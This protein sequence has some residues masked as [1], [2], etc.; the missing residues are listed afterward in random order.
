MRWEICLLFII[1]LSFASGTDVFIAIFPGAVII[2]AVMLALLRMAADAFSLPS[3]S[4]YV[5]TELGELVSGVILALIVYAFI[6]GSDQLTTILTGK[7]ATDLAMAHF[8]D[9]I[10]KYLDVYRGIIRIGTQL[11]A[12]VSFNT[13]QVLPAMF[14]SWGW[15]LG[16]YAGLAPFLTSLSMAVQ[17]VS[18]NILLYQSVLLL[19]S[20]SRSVIGPIVLPIALALRL[21]PF[22]RQAGTALV[23][24]CIS[25]LV[26]FPWSV[27][28]V[29]QI[30][31]QN[32]VPYPDPT[33]G[34]RI[35]TILGTMGVNFPSTEVLEFLCQN[36]AFRFFLSLNELGWVAAVCPIVALVA[37][38]STCAAATVGYA[39]CFAAEFY[40]VFEICFNTIV[41]EVYPLVVAG[42]QLVYNTIGTMLISASPSQAGDIFDAMYPFMVDVNNLV[43]MGYVDAILISVFTIVGA[44]SVS[45]ALGGEWYMIRF[46]RLV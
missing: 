9:L 14:M 1:G 43:M 29:S 27:V 25:A 21:I 20:F 40:A 24:I 42:A 4:A 11:R 44:R 38:S 37:A 36:D 18:N 7:S 15:S 35:T 30:H 33:A 31:S 34:G 5:K 10:N 17:G 16:P 46:Q 19:L 12:M 8:A 39:A 6:I 23:A 22:T 45:A 41:Y 26:I 28:F 3:L 2:V 13:N 32:V